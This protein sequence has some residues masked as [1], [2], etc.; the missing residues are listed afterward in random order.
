ML[1]STWSFQRAIHKQQEWMR[2]YPQTDGGQTS[3]GTEENFTA[4]PEA[5]PEGHLCGKPKTGLVRHYLEKET[6]FPHSLANTQP[7][8]PLKQQKQRV[9]KAALGLTGLWPSLT[10]HLWWLA[11]TA[12]LTQLGKKVSVRYYLGQFR[13]YAGLWG[14]I[15]IVFINE[16]IS[17]LKSMAGF[18]IWGLGL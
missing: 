14:I 17:C 8:L 6:L 10:S 9:Q 16:G 4:L 18:L 1:I 5:I 3:S 11:L 13:M 7:L 2:L 12:D 15:L